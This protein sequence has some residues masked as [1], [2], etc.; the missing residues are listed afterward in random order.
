MKTTATLLLAALLAL[1]GVGS[2]SAA[3]PAYQ[4]SGKIDASAFRGVPWGADLKGNRNF[5]L[6]T[7]ND[8]VMEKARD[9]AGELGRKVAV[10][11][12]RVPASG[13]TVYFASNEAAGEGVIPSCNQIALNLIATWYGGGLPPPASF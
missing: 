6:V 8:I 7:P 13:V 12:F 11:T 3:E 1:A 9:L 5:L 4:P 2:A 10:D